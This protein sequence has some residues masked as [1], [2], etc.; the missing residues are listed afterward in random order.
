MRTW[1]IVN[2]FTS[3]EIAPEVWGR[4]ETD[5]YAYMVEELR[6]MLV[7]PQG[8]VKTRPGSR[9]VIKTKYPDRKSRLIPFIFSEEQS[10]ILEFGHYYVR[11]H[12]NEGWVEDAGYVNSY[13][14]DNSNTLF[15]YE[16]SDVSSGDIKVFLDGVEQTLTTH[17][18]IS[19]INTATNQIDDFTVPASWDTDYLTNGTDWVLGAGVATSVGYD[20]PA[21]VQTP[22]NLAQGASLIA[23]VTVDSYSNH[24][25]QT[26]DTDATDVALTAGVEK[27]IAVVTLPQDYESANYSG[28]FRLNVT[29]AGTYSYKVTRNGQVVEESGVLASTTGNNDITIS[30]AALPATYGGDVIRIMVTAYEGGV[31]PTIT[32]TTLTTTLTVDA[33]ITSTPAWRMGAVDSNDVITSFEQTTATGAH[34]AE[35]EL[36]MPNDFGVFIQSDAGANLALSSPSLKYAVDGHIIT[37]VTAPPLGA[38]IQILDNTKV[39]L[40]S[41][42]RN[43]LSAEAAVDYVFEIQ[44]PYDENVLDELYYVQANDVMVFTHDYWKPFELTRYGAYDWRFEYNAMTGAPWEDG[45][46][47]PEQ[48]YP[49]TCVFF[50]ERLYFG[51]TVSQPQTLWGS[52]VADFH[53]F[54][55]PGTPVADD[56]VEYT[57]A[58]YT[59]EAIEWLSSE[60]VL[61]VGTSSTEHRLAPTG[62]IGADSVPTVSRMTAYGGAHLIP[63]IMGNTTVFIQAGR[64]Q[65]RSYAQ[66]TQSVIEKWDSI[67]LDWVSAH[68]TRNKVKQP[69]YALKPYSALFMPTEDGDMLSMTYEPNMSEKG[70]VGWSRHITDG[71]VESIAIIP[72]DKNQQVWAIVK[73]ESGDE[74]EGRYVE[75]FDD[76][77]YTDSTLTYPQEGYE[78]DP[79][80]NSVSNLD[81]LE[82]KTV[83]VKADGGTHPDRVVESGTISLND[84]YQNVEVGLKYTPHV[85]LAHHAMNDQ[86][87]QLQGQKGRWSSVFVR[88]VESAYPL[89]NGERPPER[90]AETGMGNVEP[91]VTGD[92]D[93]KNLGWDRGKHVIISQDLPFPLHITALFGVLTVNQG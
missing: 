60:R 38:N 20:N 42:G 17:Y 62:Y 46:Y 74:V 12:K 15:A 41:G 87:A 82:G 86:P 80:V 7:N 63:V 43:G 14:G 4:T 25:E 50:Q 47:T 32:G 79:A 33:V 69:M 73:R 75:F 16:H 21:L 85:K 24:P 37:F 59:H 11:F 19:S 90:Q 53:D 56:P 2:A 45:G 13:I 6:N 1:D 40:E 29:G 5:Q 54:T 30:S 8:G 3:G 57:I 91:V 72:E 71:I 58:A 89:I 28:A 18:T 61:I 23:S 66:S 93:I 81:H 83:C 35:F 22:V 76:D 49:R 36:N 10:Y 88:I 52:R 55:I 51:G 92:V 77:L 65:V 64:T 78:N 48:G 31:T 68:L 67:E 39:G 26:Q 84:Y 9:F 70:Q 44:S 27:E 34:T